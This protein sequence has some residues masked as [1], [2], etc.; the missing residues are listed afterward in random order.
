MH[1]PET[2]PANAGLRDQFRLNT[3]PP[4]SGSGTTPTPPTPPATT[5][6]P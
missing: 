3:F 6:K 1:P 2:D 5:S 4:A